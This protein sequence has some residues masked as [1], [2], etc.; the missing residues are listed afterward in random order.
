M[1]TPAPGDEPQHVPPP[2]SALRLVVGGFLMG[3]ANLV[4]GV[5]GG[6][7]ILAIGLYDRFIASV[8]DVTRLRLTRP[9]VVFLG[10]MGVGLVAAILGLSGPAVWLVT[11]HRWVAYSLFVGMTLGGVPLLLRVL[12]PFGATELVCAVLGVAAMAAFAFAL[13]DTSLPH[14]AL[15]F[16]LVGALAASSMILPGISGSYILLVFGMYD[17]IVGSVRP[18][19]LLED[20]GEALGIV[21]PT[22]IGVVLGIGL[23][24]NVLKWTLRSF[25][26]PA[27]AVLLG[28]LVGS[29][30][31]LWPFQRAVHPR[32]VSRDGVEAVEL[33]L[34]GADVEAVRAE[35][36]T[37]LLPAEAAELVRV[38]GGATRGELKRRGLELETYRPGLGEIGIALALFGV[39][40][41]LTRS[42]AP[43]GDA[44]A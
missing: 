3:F 1:R 5:S 15:V 32:L 11:E 42:L 8:A 30:F 43:R 35:T 21:V 20:P 9:L 13:G 27:H 29:V 31:G 40:F 34:G 39:G 16:G 14:N 6:T 37:V 25:E 41:A 33:L 19:V 28:L 2:A 18:S 4:P 24:S 23:L 17:V 12:R 44:A 10:L 26:R 38:H 36:G 7:M 22:G